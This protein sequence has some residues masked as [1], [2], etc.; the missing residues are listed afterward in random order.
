M[1]GIAFGLREIA[2]VRIAEDSAADPGRNL[3]FD[4]V[5]AATT[6]ES[7]RKLGNTCFGSDDHRNVCGVAN[8]AH[9]L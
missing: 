8:V 9:P 3:G 1:V 6:L 4:V 5:Y 7:G 2:D